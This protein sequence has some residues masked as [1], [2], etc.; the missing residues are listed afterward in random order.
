MVEDTLNY[1]DALKKKG[2]L[3]IGVGVGPY[4]EDPKFWDILKEISSPGQAIRVKFDKF[5]SIRNTLVK[6]S[7]QEFRE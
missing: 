6:S 3:I 4:V 5:Q 1:A 2:I 7:C